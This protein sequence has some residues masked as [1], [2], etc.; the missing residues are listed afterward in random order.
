MKLYFALGCNTCRSCMF[1][2]EMSHKKIKHYYPDRKDLQ[3]IKTP[4]V[5]CTS[6]DQYKEPLKKYGEFT[7]EEFE[8]NRTNAREY[9]RL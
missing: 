6:G 3:K 1:G 7:C 5:E 9:K 2:Y 8:L 4:V